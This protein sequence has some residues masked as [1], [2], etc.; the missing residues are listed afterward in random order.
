MK[1]LV[2][3]FAG[4]GTGKSTT[5]AGVFYKMK[6]QHINSEYIQ[7]YAKDKTWMGDHFSLGIQPYVTVKQ[8]YRQ[9]RLR[10]KVDV[11]ITDGC[12][13]N[14]LLYH[15]KYVNDDF[16]YWLLSAHRSF[17]NLNIF[18]ERNV[19]HHGY[20]AS[21]RSQ[22]LTQ[23]MQIDQ[24]TLDLLDRLKEPYM[25]LQMSDQ[26]VDQILDLVKEKL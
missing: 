24:R 1:L 16:T 3:L 17:P 6:T 9:E 19:Q 10:D 18:I 22:D 13:L 5:A 14:G 7:E 12:I 2:N 26:L 25:R 8:L 20:E 21:G 11:A 15:C 4:P 23:A